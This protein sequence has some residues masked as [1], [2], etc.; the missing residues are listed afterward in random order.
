MLPGP[1][2][3]CFCRPGI[4]TFCGAPVVSNLEEMRE[5]EIK[6]HIAL[7]E[8]RLHTFLRVVLGVVFVWAS[9]LKVIDPQRFADIVQAY[10]VLPLALVNPVALI[11][12]WVEAVCGLLLIAGYMTRGSALVVDGLMFIFIVTFVV[13]LFR[14]IDVSCGCFSLSL[15]AKNQLW[16]YLIRD[17]AIFMAG[18]W[19]LLYEIKK[20]RFLTG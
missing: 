13:N 14:G 1:L 3:G 16:I 12:P 20:D 11:L 4:G 18:V 10:R 6:D 15:E 7:K 19:V 17:L 5:M 2:E 8:S 9:W